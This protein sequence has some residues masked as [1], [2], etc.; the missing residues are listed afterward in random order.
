M[1]WIVFA[2]RKLILILEFHE[3]L[4]GRKDGCQGTWDPVRQ[5]GS[6]LDKITTA[7]SY[8]AHPLAAPLPIVHWVTLPTATTA[9]MVSP[10]S[11]LYL[12]LVE[13]PYQTHISRYS[14]P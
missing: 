9:S 4:V 8:P 6:R 5:K 2:T 3:L 7:S 14:N 1:L 11:L 13:H 12:G 10:S